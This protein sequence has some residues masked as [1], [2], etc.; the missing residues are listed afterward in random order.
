MDNL[1]GEFNNLFGS[2]GNDVSKLSGSL[3][4]QVGA[5]FKRSLPGDMPRT[6]SKRAKL[7]T[8]SPSAADLVAK[9][10]LGID[11][12]ANVSVELDDEVSLHAF[13]SRIDVVRLT[14]FV[15]G[16]EIARRR[17]RRGA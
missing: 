4:D 1:F 16:E 3:E 13:S 2:L 14:R 10:N 12:D 17:E 6:R 9:L 15:P 5:K 7:V 11:V 8:R